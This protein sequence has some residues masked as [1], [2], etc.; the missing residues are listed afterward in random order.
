MPDAGHMLQ[1]GLT[2]QYPRVAPATVSDN[3]NPIAEIWKWRRDLQIAEMRLSGISREQA[4]ASVP[5]VTL[6]VVDVSFDAIADPEQRAYFMELPT[7][8]VLPDEDIDRL[9]EV[10]GQ[11]MRQSPEYDAIVQTMGGSLAQ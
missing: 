8:F 5:E 11:L 3:A 6:D 4:E 10:A 7:S 1:S 2:Q 9:V